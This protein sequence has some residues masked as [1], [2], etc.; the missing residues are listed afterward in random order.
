MLGLSTGLIYPSYTQEDIETGWLKVVYGS[1]QN[2]TAS[3]AVG[4]YLDNFPRQTP[5]F[6]INDFFPAVAQADSA[7]PARIIT[8]NF[9]KFITKLMYFSLF[10]YNSFKVYQRSQY[11][12]SK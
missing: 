1:A 11:N 9:L 3:Q 6:G 12:I 8:N 2:S 7:A 5:G 10:I 4:L